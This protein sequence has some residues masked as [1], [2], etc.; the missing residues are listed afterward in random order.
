MIGCPNKYRLL[1][2]LLSRNN[3]NISIKYID[4]DIYIQIIVLLYAD[5][6]VLFASSERDLLTLLDSFIE[7]CE[8][9][10]LDVNVDKT[11]I[12]VFGDRLGRSRHVA[13]RNN[14]FEVVD[15]FKYLGNMFKKTQKFCKGQISHSRTSQKS[16]I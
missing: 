12:L 4:L 16:I 6:T 15:S 8:T 1:Y 14:N 11:K 10:K 13:V 3:C 9:W 7:Y 2:Y 5:D